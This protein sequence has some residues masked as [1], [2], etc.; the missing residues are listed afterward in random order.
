[1]L[2]Q[3]AEIVLAVT[4]LIQF[5][6]TLFAGQPNP[7]LREFGQR[8]GVWL[9]QVVA[10]LTYVGDAR[11]WPFGLEWPAAEPVG[12][13]GISGFGMGGGVGGGGPVVELEGGAVGEMDPDA[14][15]A[16]RHTRR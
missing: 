7:S 1:M 4:V 14:V 5:F 8:L 3:I 10:F 12:G 6:W 9:Q 15:V 13:G 16:H 11:P 2:W